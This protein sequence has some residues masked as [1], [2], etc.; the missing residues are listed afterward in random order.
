MTTLSTHVLDLARGGPAPEVA[1][2]L[3]HLSGETWTVLHHARTNADGRVPALLPPGAPDSGT[4][5]LTFH[6][7][8]YFASTGT[9]GFYPFVPIVFH[10]GRPGEHYHV[11]LLLGPYGYS[12]Y[13][14]S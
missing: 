6:T 2:T 3:E 7:A 13:R 12:T 5:R 14:G 11:P 9:T 1:V 10:V 8:A 4:F